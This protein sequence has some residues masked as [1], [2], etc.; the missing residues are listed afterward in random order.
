MRVLDVHSHDELLP[1]FG[2]DRIQAQDRLG[3]GSA[4]GDRRVRAARSN[5]DSRRKGRHRPQHLSERLGGVVASDLESEGVEYGGR[6][7][8]ARV[9]CLARSYEPRL[10]VAVAFVSRGEA[11]SE[12][13]IERGHLSTRPSGGSQSGSAL[14]PDSANSSSSAPRFRAAGAIERSGHRE[15]PVSI[16]P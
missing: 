16:G 4:I 14:L 6:G 15:D 1:G 10:G 11:R 5:V 8:T 3:Q 13:S 9:G 7:G 12:N 2:Y